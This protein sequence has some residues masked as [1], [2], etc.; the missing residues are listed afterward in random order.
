MTAEAKDT[1]IN[2]FII[3]KMMNEFFAISVKKVLS[4]LEMQKITEVPK[5]PSYM[6][7]VMNL[8][9]EV[10]PVI[11]SYLKFGIETP[12][13]VTRNT[14]ILVLEVQD[15]QNESIRLGLLVDYVDEVLEIKED[16][17]LPPPNI[18][19]SF[20]SE[21]I[22]GMYQKDE[23]QFIML[24]DVDKLLALN[25]II[26]LSKTTDVLKTEENI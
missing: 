18:G 22:T 13:K 14:C 9:G 11:D 5:A 21:Y 12:L 7:G 24:L 6:K 3:F 1:V 19:R 23:E 26:Q 17:I 10:I 2:S 16:K 25:A 20:E 8:R 4:I 15:N